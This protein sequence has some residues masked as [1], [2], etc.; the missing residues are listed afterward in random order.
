AQASRIAQH[1]SAIA[2]TGKM[3]QEPLS[4]ASVA[5]S[6]LAMLLLFLALFAI[7]GFTVYR[8]AF[9]IKPAGDDFELIGE[10]R[11]GNT[12]GP[13]KLYTTSLSNKFYRPSKSLVIWLTGRG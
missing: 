9:A 8:D 3:T 2:I 4:T 11:R 1:R 6:R 5:P 12:Q 13:L 7:E 10:I